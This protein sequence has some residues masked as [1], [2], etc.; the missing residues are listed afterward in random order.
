MSCFTDVDGGDYYLPSIKNLT[1]KSGSNTLCMAIYHDIISYKP[2]F[3]R[4]SMICH[5]NSCCGKNCESRIS[6]DC[7]GPRGAYK[8]DVDSAV[9]P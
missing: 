7:R 8:I 4:C 2:I 5:L 3:P 1:P 9:Q 6:K